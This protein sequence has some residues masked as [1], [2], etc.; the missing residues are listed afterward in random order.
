M[1]FRSPENILKQAEE[2]LKYR[3]RTGLVGPAVSAHPQ[4]E[5]ILSELQQRG[6]GISVSSLRIRPL[7]T[8]ALKEM[9][10][11]KS[12]TIALAPEA[13]SQRLRDLIKKG[14][15]EEDIYKAIE[16]SAEHGVRQLKLY[17]M[18]GLPTETD[19]DIEAIIRLTHDCKAILERMNPGCRISLSVAPFVPK[20]GTP[21]QWLPMEKTAVLESRIA[22]LKKSLQ[23]SG[24]Q[25]KAESPAW[26]RVQGALAR[27]DSS[28]AAVLADMREFSLSEWRAALE[29]HGIYIDSELDRR[30]DVSEKLPWCSSIPASRPK[31]S[32][33]N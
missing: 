17:Y 19:D 15:S 12:K 33:K 27:G 30:R 24:V 21:F 10:K 23:K 25:V 3:K 4:F 13:G 14:V 9:M 7:S 16:L 8:L 11:S 2:G 26:S 22:T 32:R 18:I 31:N 29:K 5:Q 1:R 20:P 6:A 28:L